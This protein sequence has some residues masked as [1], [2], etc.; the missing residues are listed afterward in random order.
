M[1][2]IPEVIPKVQSSLD[3][4]GNPVTKK[5]RP[6]TY[7]LLYFITRELK[8]KDTISISDDLSVSEWSINFTL[9]DDD[10]EDTVP[11]IIMAHEDEQIMTFDVY[12]G[13]FDLNDHQRMDI[14]SLI[15]SVNNQLL[16]GSIQLFEGNTI[17]Y[18]YSID[19]NNVASEDPQYSGPHLI[20]PQLINNVFNHLISASRKFSV[21]LIE[22]LSK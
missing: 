1:N 7:A 15:L 19:F 20:Q 17:R 13:E 4:N 18:H 21:E 11:L 10:D 8:Y 9:R 22:L 2:S 3:T 14:T 12:F 6:L 5:I 16:I